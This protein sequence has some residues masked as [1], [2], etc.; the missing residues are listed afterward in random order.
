MKVD[1]KAEKNPCVVSLT[2]KA[3][4]DEIEPGNDDGH[5]KKIVPAQLPK[6]DEQAR[7][8]LPANLAALLPAPRLAI[9]LGFHPITLSKNK[10]LKKSYLIVY[11]ALSTR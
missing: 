9:L 3:D 11:R 1:Q 5:E 7:T 8:A 4:A 10:R 6:P 2:V